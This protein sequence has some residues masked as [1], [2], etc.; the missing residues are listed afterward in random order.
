MRERPHIA[1]SQIVEPF[2]HQELMMQNRNKF[3]ETPRKGSTLG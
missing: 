2:P 1:T 3:S